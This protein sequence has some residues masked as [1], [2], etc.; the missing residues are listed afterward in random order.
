MKHCSG[1]RRFQ[2]INIIQQRLILKPSGEGRS[3]EGRGGVGE[4]EKTDDDLLL[5]I[6]YYTYLA[7]EGVF[8]LLVRID[9]E[10]MG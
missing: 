2:Y 3:E 7:A 8:S 1:T 5:M 6:L 10:V 9:S 4:R